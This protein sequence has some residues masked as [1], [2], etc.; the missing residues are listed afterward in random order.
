MAWPA[1]DSAPQQMSNDSSGYV[2]DGI[3]KRAKMVH[4]MQSKEFGC[5]G[6]VAVESRGTATTRRDTT[7]A[8]NEIK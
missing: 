7:R 6:R 2:G 1:V 5:M 8:R 3:G 4:S